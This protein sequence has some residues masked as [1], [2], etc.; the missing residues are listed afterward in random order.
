MAT[1]GTSRCGSETKRVIKIPQYNHIIQIL[2]VLL[3]YQML[4]LCLGRQWQLESRSLLASFKKW[5]IPFHI[6]S[7][8]QIFA[9]VT[10]HDSLSYKKVTHFFHPLSPDLNWRL[11]YSYY[12]QLKSEQNVVASQQSFEKWPGLTPCTQ[13]VKKSDCEQLR[14]VGVSGKHIFFST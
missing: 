3:G 4:D 12:M 6:L 10:R 8:L 13:N 14:Y 1:Q 9:M 7:I 11:T 5:L 2:R